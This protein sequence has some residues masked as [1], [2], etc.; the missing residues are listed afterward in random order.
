MSLCYVSGRNE[1]SLRQLSS[2]T[3][4]HKT[5]VEVKET[6]AAAYYKSFITLDPC[7]NEAKSSLVKA[8]SGTI[9]YVCQQGCY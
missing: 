2:P 5:G 3:L 4:K 8:D 9:D 7:L 6:N 1:Q